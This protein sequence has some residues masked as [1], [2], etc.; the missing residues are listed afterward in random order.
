VD[1]PPTPLDLITGDELV[2][3]GPVVDDVRAVCSG[4]PRKLLG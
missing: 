2:Y 4:P 1:F 3:L